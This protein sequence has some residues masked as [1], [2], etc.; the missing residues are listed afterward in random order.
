MLR[1]EQDWSSGELLKQA[2]VEAKAGMLVTVTN[3]M[4]KNGMAVLT[5]QNTPSLPTKLASELALR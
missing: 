5:K 3:L 1:H 2:L 4:F